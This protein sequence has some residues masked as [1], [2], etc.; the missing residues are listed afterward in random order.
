ME[1]KE[2][3]AFRLPGYEEIPDVG[4]YLEQTVKYLN[5]YLAP[6]GDA[7]VTTSMVSNYVKMKLIPGPQR[8]QYDRAHIAQLFFVAV[9]KNVVTLEN[10]RT[11]LAVQQAKYPLE[12][13]YGTFRDALAQAFCA[14]FGM[15][16][17]PDQ[18]RAEYAE[19]ELVHHIAAVAAE[20]AYLNHCFAAMAAQEQEK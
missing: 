11:L 2:L 13:A 8:K 17:A 6:L 19:A 16:G 9:C 14:A 4:L 12:P 18:A 5:G 15:T 3:P 10:V 20:K 7:P 1:L